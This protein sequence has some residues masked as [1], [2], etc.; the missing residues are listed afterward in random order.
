MRGV[1]GV[2]YFDNVM[3]QRGDTVS[4]CNL[5]DNSDFSNGLTSWTRSGTTVSDISV[6]SVTGIS[7]SS[8][9]VLSVP[10]AAHKTAGAY[11][12][13]NLN[14]PATETLMLSAFA[15]ACSAPLDDDEDD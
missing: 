7:G 8:D 2:S 5:L 3:L 4:T 10:S 13:V 1:K 12:T 14:L 9:K 15:K 11:Q 6:K